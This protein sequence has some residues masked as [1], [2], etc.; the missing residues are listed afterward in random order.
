MIKKIPSVVIISMLILSGCKLGDS[1]NSF[2]NNNVIPPTPE[3]TPPI[4]PIPPLPLPPPVPDAVITDFAVKY[5][6]RKLNFTWKVEIKSPSNSDYFKLFEKLTPNSEYTL[7]SERIEMDEKGYGHFVTGYNI[8]DAEYKIE[9]CNSTQCVS[10]ASVHIA[11]FKDDIINDSIVALQSDAPT[12]AERFGSS[13]DISNDGLTLVVGSPYFNGKIGK[14]TVYTR[15]LP[16]DNWTMIEPN[17]AG[18]GAS[19]TQFG[20]SVSLSKNANILAISA[21]EDCFS[22]LLDAHGTGYIKV[23]EKENGNYVETATLR[24]SANTIGDSFGSL[25]KVSSDGT[26]IVG[27]GNQ[28]KD[29]L[30]IHASGGNAVTF[31]RNESG[32]WVEKQLL[33]SNNSVKTG[34]FGAGLV[35]SDDGNT[36][37]VPAKFENYIDKEAPEK[38]IATTGVVYV[39]EWNTTT[40]LWEEKA[41]LKASDAVKYGYFGAS[42]ALS[43][44][45]TTLAVGAAYNQAALNAIPD[46]TT[47]TGEVYLFN[48]QPDGSWKETKRLVP[49]HA[50]AKDTFGTS[51]AMS[52]DGKYLIVGSPREDGTGSGLNALET[53]VQSDSNSGA[54]YMFEC[55]ADFSCKQT[56]YIKSTLPKI[57]SHFGR[58]VSFMINEHHQQTI[59][60]MEISP[61]SVGKIFQY[62]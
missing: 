16:T 3:V 24:S 14:A 4:L 8:L 10:S 23:F 22:D 61:E 56:G 20:K 11:D 6:Q 49:E 29:D 18:Q 53:D 62:Q 21:Q 34:M 13:F 59:T 41:Y 39:F 51:V 26:K 37:I 31:V 43:K 54:V 46:E 38:N 19:C 52:D 33:Q 25:V 5:A 36:L 60:T 9:L 35:L 48:K 30:D 32:A 40:S 44:D 45:K 1:P 27:V 57:N 17:I 12:S 47:R 50:A 2:S 7:V 28:G 42:V 58:K 55:N 15:A